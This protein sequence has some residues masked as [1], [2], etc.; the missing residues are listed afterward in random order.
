MNITKGLIVFSLLA[1]LAIV[2]FTIFSISGVYAD[3]SKYRASEY[4]TIILRTLLI[5]LIACWPWFL[6][7]RSAS[8]PKKGVA[9]SFFSVA[10][11]VAFAITFLPVYTGQSLEF[12][13]DMIILIVGVWVAYPLCLAILAA[14]SYE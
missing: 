2:F 12:A 13:L 6:G 9:L 3:F 7:Y 5:I 8:N 10:S 14:H 4:F 1:N 11:T